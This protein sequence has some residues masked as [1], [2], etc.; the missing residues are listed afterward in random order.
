MPFANW[1]TTLPAGDRQTA[2]Y[3][4]VD[5]PFADPPV[6]TTQAFLQNHGVH[7]VY[8]HVAEPGQIQAEANAGGRTSSPD[9]V[10]I[11]SVDLP[12]LHGL[13][14]HLPERHTTRPRS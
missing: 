11:G 4:M 10:V 8:S 5:D 1:V 9:I 7:T 6:Q 3:P 12:S 2:A 13:R 14:A